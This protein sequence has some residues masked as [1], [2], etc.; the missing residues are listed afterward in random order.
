MR[1]QC[2]KSKFVIFQEKIL[3]VLKCYNFLWVQRKLNRSPAASFANCVMALYLLK[4]HLQTFLSIQIPQKYQILIFDTLV[5]IERYVGVSS[6]RVRS[7]MR[8]HQTCSNTYDILYIYIC[9][10][11]VGV[12]NKLY[13]THGTYIIMWKHICPC[14]TFWTNLY[15]DKFC[16][17]ALQL[18]VSYSLLHSVCILFLQV[19]KTVLICR[20]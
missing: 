16:N 17:T 13:K 1:Q 20:N 5:P 18:P 12:D 3:K 2:H 6:M 15:P 10:A 19:R 11:F 7:E 14:A 8:V 4:V 9:C